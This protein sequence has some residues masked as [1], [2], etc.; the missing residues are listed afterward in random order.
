[1][2]F[3]SFDS[4]LKMNSIISNCEPQI[5]DQEPLRNRWLLPDPTSPKFF[6]AKV[7]INFCFISGF[8]LSQSSL[9]ISRH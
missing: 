1:M 6:F 5:P 7:S 2:P 9:L 4:I 8:I 3:I